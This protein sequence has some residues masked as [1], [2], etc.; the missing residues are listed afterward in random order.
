VASGE[1][2]LERYVPAGHV[3][4]FDVVIMDVLMGGMDGHAAV[5]QIR[6]RHAEQAVVMATGWAPD[7]QASEPHAVIWLSKPYAVSDLA[8]AIANARQGLW[9]PSA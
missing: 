9:K 2:A 4:G 6:A 8:A 3:G 5:Q 7:D 1:E